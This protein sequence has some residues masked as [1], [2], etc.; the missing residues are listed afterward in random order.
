MSPLHKDGVQPGT[1]CT[2]MPDGLQI[3]IQTGP[4]NAFSQ[5][6]PAFGIIPRADDDREPQTFQIIAGDPFRF[7]FV[8]DRVIVLPVADDDGF[9]QHGME[10]IM[11]FGLMTAG[12]VASAPPGIFLGK[13]HIV[14]HHGFDTAGGKHIME[15]ADV[16]CQFFQIVLH[17]H[18]TAFRRVGFIAADVEI[19]RIFVQ[20]Q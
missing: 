12:N 19:G 20:I 15:K 7:L 8:A 3:A 6:Q 17:A 9:G 14:P 1:F 11:A 13:E 2:V 10:G 16:I 5:T 18:G 4:D